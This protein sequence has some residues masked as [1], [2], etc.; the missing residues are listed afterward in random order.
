MI[1]FCLRFRSGGL[2]REV[3]TLTMCLVSKRFFFFFSLFVRI[4][5]LGYDFWWWR[6]VRLS[7]YV[8]GGFLGP[9]KP[10]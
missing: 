10:E 6:G 3:F 4:K 9:G 5:G 1:C 2:K 7:E 8:V